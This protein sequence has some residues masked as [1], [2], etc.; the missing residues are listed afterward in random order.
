MNHKGNTARGP[1]QVVIFIKCEIAPEGQLNLQLLKI[2]Q[3]SGTVTSGRWCQT[4]ILQEPPSVGWD[5]EECQGGGEGDKEEEKTVLY[6][7]RIY[8]H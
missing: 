2:F 3:Q 7:P 4:W 8:C 6:V 1:C 5:R